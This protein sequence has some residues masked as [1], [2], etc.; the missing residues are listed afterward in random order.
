MQLGELLPLCVEMMFFISCSVSLLTDT[1]KFQVS[2][3]IVFSL[4]MN[5][6]SNK[7]FARDV[8]IIIYVQQR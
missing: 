4:H 1:S 5:Y 7:T 6:M 8:K 3:C 2:S